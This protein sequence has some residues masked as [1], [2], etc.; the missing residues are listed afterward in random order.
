MKYFVEDWIVDKK[1]FIRPPLFHIVIILHPLKGVER[2]RYSGKNMLKDSLSIADPEAYQIMQKEKR[3]QKRGLE[4][5]A[6]EN[7]TSKAVHDALGSSLSNKYSE[8]YP[9]ARSFYLDITEAMNSS[10]RWKDCVKAVLFV[11]I[12][13]SCVLKCV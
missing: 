13:F 3:R 8:G 4:L 2:F 6:S 7:F 9:G 10:I 12:N 1:D 11:Y 5:I